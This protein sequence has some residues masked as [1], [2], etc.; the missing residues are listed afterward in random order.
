MQFLDNHLGINYYIG[1]P[2]DKVLGELL[3]IHT[4]I[5]PKCLWSQC[6]CLTD[7]TF[8]LLLIMKLIQYF[9]F[10]CQ[11]WHWNNL[12]NDSLKINGSAF[13]WKMI[14]NP[15]LITQVQEVI[16]PSCLSI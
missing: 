13:L 14:L 7:G 6:K 1:V 5:L 16:F 11:S 8:V 4:S 9:P 2:Q 3:T 10:F 15:D 12:N